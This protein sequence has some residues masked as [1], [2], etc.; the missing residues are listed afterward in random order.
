MIVYKPYIP[1]N[2]SRIVD[3]VK[4]KNHAGFVYVKVGEDHGIPIYEMRKPTPF[5]RKCIVANYLARHSPEVTKVHFLAEKLGVTDRTIQSLLKEFIST[6]ALIAYPNYG[7]D[8]RQTGNLYFWTGKFDH[9]VGSPTLDDLYSKKDKYGFRSFTWDD[10][11][12][13]PGQYNSV[14]DKIDKYYQYME[15][16]A[17]K[18]R[19]TRKHDAR[20]R[21][22]IKKMHALHVRDENGVP[23]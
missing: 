16:I 19:L 20:K 12:V 4:P 23:Y 10:F 18:K 8:G 11:K 15:L 2:P 22:S 6:G 17:I 5:E 14:Q 13:V 7:R 9:V 1:K 21:R 3:T